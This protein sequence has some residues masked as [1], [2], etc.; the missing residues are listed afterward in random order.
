MN[1]RDEN[2]EITAIRA[3]RILTKK[4]NPP[5]D[6]LINANIIT[7]LVEFLSRV[8]KYVVSSTLFPNIS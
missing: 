1:S 2:K 3:V 8:N 5:I 7:K 4:R 6:I